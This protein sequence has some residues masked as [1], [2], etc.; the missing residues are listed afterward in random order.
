MKLT[1]KYLQLDS[2]NILAKPWPL[3][4]LVGFISR[5]NSRIMEIYLLLL[6]SRLGWMRIP[7]TTTEGTYAMI[8]ECKT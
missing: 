4:I 7:F 3:T 2:S 6:P 5:K 1:S 8:F